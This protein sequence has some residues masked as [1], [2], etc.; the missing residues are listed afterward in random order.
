MIAPIRSLLL[1]ACLIGGGNVYAS[2][3]EELENLRKRISALQ[4][5]F[6]KTNESKST[7]ADALRES[8][9]TISTSNQYQKL[10]LIFD[11]GTV[12]DGSANFTYLFDDIIL[13]NSGT[14]PPSGTQMNLPVTFD[15]ATVNYG[16]VGFGGAEVSTIV[17]D[18]TLPSNT[19]LA[20]VAIH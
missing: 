6:E 11:L 18:P 1:M 13:T 15:D 2:Q 20:Y 16:L 12:G 17:A 9:R 8:E 3:Q 14:P 7:A 10:V 19:V 4:Q 5:D